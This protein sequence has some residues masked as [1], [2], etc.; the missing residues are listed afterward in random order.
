MNEQGR[1]AAAAT[2]QLVLEP[3]GYVRTELATKV[4]AARQPRS[5]AGAVGRIE[6]L[7]ARNFEHAL[8]NL[9]EW[10][11]IWVLFWFDRNEG[12][13]PKVLPPR[14]RSGRKGV[15]ATRSPHR[16]NPLGLSAV[17]LERVDGL[18]LH[19]SDVDMLDGTPVLDIKPYVAYT[20]VIADAGAGWLTSEDAP[21]D[22]IPE[23][24]VL[25]DDA[26]AEQ[27][28]WIEARTGLPLRA[29][30]TATLAL[31]PEPHPYRRIRR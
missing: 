10:Q 12:W 27:A 29:R 4:E 2:K 16:P 25:W 13:R 17:R 19:V 1:A 8:S 20:D 23:F 9:A 7:P 6:L 31:G 18:T 15:F 24:E 26:A 5:G 14:S 3:I 28:A 22:P 11:F 21:R 30:A